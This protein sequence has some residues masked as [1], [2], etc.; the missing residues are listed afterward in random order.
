MRSG[1]DQVEDLWI[2]YMSTF[3]WYACDVD[4][5]GRSLCQPPLQAAYEASD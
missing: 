4:D 5:G 2:M 3:P 1:K